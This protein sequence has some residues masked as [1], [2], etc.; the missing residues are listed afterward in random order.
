MTSKAIREYAN[1]LYTVKTTIKNIPEEYRSNA[2]VN[3]YVS[4]NC[5]KDVKELFKSDLLDSEVSTIISNSIA[6]L[7]ELK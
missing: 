2:I 7:E 5:L 6:K 1:L 4:D 3:F